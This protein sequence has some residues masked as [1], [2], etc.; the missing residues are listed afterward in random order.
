MLGF[1]FMEAWF[2]VD[3]DIVHIHGVP[4]LGH[5]PTEDHVHHHL[6]GGWRI[7]KAK[8][9]HCWL[10]KPFWGE[11]GSFPFVA[12]FDMNIIISPTD[13][14][15]GEQGASAEAI[16]SLGNKGGNVSVFLSPF[17]DWAIVL[18]WSQLSIFLFNKE[19]IG[20]IRTP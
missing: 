12:M 1:Q 11:K 3:C 16:Y 17:V 10:E 19:E 13:I 6:E 4:T 7:G 5:F 15:F 18:H 20:Y 9:H 2:G 8:E 14:K